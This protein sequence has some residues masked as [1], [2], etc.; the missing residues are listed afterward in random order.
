MLEVYDYI[1]ARFDS[2]G[3]KL[4]WWV[5][6]FTLTLNDGRTFTNKFTRY[7]EYSN[8]G[9]ELNLVILLIIVPLI[10]FSRSETEYFNTWYV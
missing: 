7:A 2:H 8:V 5:R 4:L 6:N 3:W 1:D 9:L 10:I